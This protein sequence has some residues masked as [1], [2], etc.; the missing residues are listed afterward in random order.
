MEMLTERQASECWCPFA[1][2]MP[3]GG[4]DDAA[5]I[6]MAGI[7]PDYS[8]EMAALFPCIGSRCMAWRGE[9]SESFKRRAEAEFRK[10]GARL[11]PTSDDL[12]GYCGMAGRP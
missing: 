12:V 6:A 7:N 10:T 11:K 2:R 3:Y 8:D 9:E 4:A 5:E 1:K